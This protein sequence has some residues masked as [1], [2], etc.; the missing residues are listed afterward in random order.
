[1]PVFR[2]LLVSL[3]YCSDTHHAYT[4]HLLTGQTAPISEDKNTPI[5]MKQHKS[6]PCI[7]RH[8][9]SEVT[10]LVQGSR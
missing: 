6:L 2:G 3:L 7:K 9:D 1:M 5:K 4:I 8:S 10:N